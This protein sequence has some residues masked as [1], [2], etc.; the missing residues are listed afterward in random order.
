MDITD[1]D[2]YETIVH[3]SDDRTVLEMLSVNKKFNQDDA[4]RRVLE[5]RYPYLIA[6]RKE[7][8]TWKALYLRMIYYIEKLKEKKCENKTI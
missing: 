8:E 3:S 4:F 1:K 7:G 2:V 6:F 5:R